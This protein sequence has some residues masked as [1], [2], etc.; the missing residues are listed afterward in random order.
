[1]ETATSTWLLV[2]S[3]RA[4]EEVL[5]IQVKGLFPWGG[6]ESEHDKPPGSFKFV[7]L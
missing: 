4:K 3:I 6:E 7:F 5:V 2:R 1:M